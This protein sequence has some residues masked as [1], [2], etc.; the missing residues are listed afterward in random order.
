MARDIAALQLGTMIASACLARFLLLLAVVPRSN[1]ACGCKRGHFPS[2]PSAGPSHP[3]P[4]S[5]PKGKTSINWLETSGFVLLFVPFCY[6]HIHASKELLFL[7]STFLLES[8]IISEVI[9]IR[10]EGSSFHA[11]KVPW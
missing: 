7:F 4:N 3:H 8:T 11:K 10:R 2:S 1:T 9:E 5:A 6:I